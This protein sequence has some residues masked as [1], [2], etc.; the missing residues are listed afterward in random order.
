MNVLDAFRDWV[1]LATDQADEQKE[2]WVG[3][4]AMNRPTIQKKFFINHLF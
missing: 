3:F 4:F 1:C 2:F